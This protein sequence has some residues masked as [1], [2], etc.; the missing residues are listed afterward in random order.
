MAQRS[1]VYA[2]PQ[3]HTVSFT[4]VAKKHIEQLRKY[5]KVYEWDEI[6]DPRHLCDHALRA[7]YPP[8]HRRG[9]ALA[10]ADILDRVELGCGA[11]LPEREIAQVRE[12]G[13]LRGRGQRRGQRACHQAPSARGR[14]MRAVGVVPPILSSAAAA[15]KRCTWY[16]TVS[17][18]NGIRHRQPTHLRSETKLCKCFIDINSI[19][20]RSC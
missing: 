11:R 15:K 17:T 3:W 18:G 16:R 10:A 19:I 4:L 13:R 6:D 7:V 14:S 9:L 8:Y 2:Y 5:T 20:T 12:G 1:I